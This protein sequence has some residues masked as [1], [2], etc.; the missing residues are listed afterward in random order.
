ME[1]KNHLNH[2]AQ[3]LIHAHKVHKVNA[4]PTFFVNGTKIESALTYEQF[5]K[6]LKALT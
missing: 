3:Q 2:L 4:T 6:I 1:N 5:D